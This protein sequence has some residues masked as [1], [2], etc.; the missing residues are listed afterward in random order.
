MTIYRP[1]VMM[2][3]IFLFLVRKFSKW[4]KYRVIVFLNGGDSHNKIK[5]SRHVKDLIK[6]INMDSIF[7]LLRDKYLQY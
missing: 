6:P 3:T 5:K 1:N 7:K 2:K 4:L